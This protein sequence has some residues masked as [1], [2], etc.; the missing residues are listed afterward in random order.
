MEREKKEGAMTNFLVKAFIKDSEKIE[1][2]S[3]RTAYGKLSGKVG[4]LCNLILCAGKFIAG[5][6]TGS[7]SIAADAANNL[8]DASSSVI[9][10][11]GFKLSEKSADRE[12]P[13]GHGRYEYLAGF[14]VAA[15]IVAIGFGL[16][17]D[18]IEKIINPTEVEFGILPAA[19]LGASILVKF[20][21]MLFN[22]KLERKIHS[23]TLKATFADSRNDVITTSAVLAAF[24]ISHYFGI[25]LDGIMAA[26]VAVFIL[27]SGIGLIKEAMDPI[28]GKA[29]DEEQVERIRE[30]ILSYKGVLGTHDLMIHDYGPGRQFASV[31]VEVPDSMPLVKCHEI[32]D[33]IERDFLREG[34][35]MLVHPDPIASSGSLEG[36]I[37]A[38]LCEI[39][40][41]IDERITIHDLRTVH[42]S[43]ET[44]VIFDCVL[45]RDSGLSEQEIR[46]EI[47]RFIAVKFPK[48]RCI[49]SFDSGFA[50]IPKSEAHE[51]R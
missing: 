37:N 47:S 16:L 24:L 49:I 2:P 42:C 40:K 35:N 25:K 31:H 20:W 17:R 4:I 33:K 6:L 32:I 38:E 45:P 9:S 48:C 1:N 23:E 10:L 18:G 26:A 29:P 50:S 30:K 11:I 27:Y 3:V 36:K 21:M 34:L 7:V 41:K 43:D 44:K 8:S 12:H 13:Y 22:R 15:L 28:L 5:M 39:T 19:V 46:E 14:V 51:E